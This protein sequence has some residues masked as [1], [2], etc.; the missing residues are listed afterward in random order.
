M[1]T[2]AVQKTEPGI[3]IKIRVWEEGEILLTDP[4]AGHTIQ[5]V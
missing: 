5:G 4:K 1:P 2:T 3:G